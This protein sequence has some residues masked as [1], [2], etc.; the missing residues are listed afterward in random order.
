MSFGNPVRN[1]ADVF[2]IV[3]KS[4]IRTAGSFWAVLELKGAQEVRLKSPLLLFF[5]SRVLLLIIAIGTKRSLF[6]NYHIFKKKKKTK[7]RLTTISTQINI[8]IHFF[9]S[10]TLFIVR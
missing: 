4:E 5:L 1:L 9:A 2:E 3:L 7:K 10:R 8:F 6:E